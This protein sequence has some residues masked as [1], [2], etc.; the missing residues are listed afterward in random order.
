MIFLLKPPNIATTYQH[1]VLG[2]YVN[3]LK[4]VDFQD[5]LQNK[6]AAERLGDLKLERDNLEMF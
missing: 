6:E 3:F 5:S 1:P 4:P 2:K